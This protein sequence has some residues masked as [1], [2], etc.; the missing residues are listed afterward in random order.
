MSA[1]VRRRYVPTRARLSKCGLSSHG[2]FVA[3]LLGEAEIESESGEK[4][5]TF[6]ELLEEYAEG[7]SD[8]HRADPKPVIEA[9]EKL[10]DFITGL[11]FMRFGRW[12]LDD[13]SKAS[14]GQYW[15]DMLPELKVY[16]ET[17]LRGAL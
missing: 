3:S 11:L 1:R 17:R 5:M 12:P 16:Y 2:E 15:L 14:M 6:Q 10:Q 8:M 7:C 9:Y 4:A 13:E